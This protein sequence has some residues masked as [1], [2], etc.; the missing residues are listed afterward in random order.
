MAIIYYGI[1]IWDQGDAY[2]WLQ[3]YPLTVGYDV[4]ICL[5]LKMVAAFATQ[6]QLLV[7][8]THDCGQLFD[9]EKL[10]CCDECD[11]T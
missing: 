7:N 8:Q 1:V 10:I 9:K 6:R 3:V 5:T 2:H 11:G 4:F